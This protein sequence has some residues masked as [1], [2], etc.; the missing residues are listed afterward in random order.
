MISTYEVMHSFVKNQ[1][2]TSRS[3]ANSQNVPKFEK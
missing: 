3:D 1:V 2:H